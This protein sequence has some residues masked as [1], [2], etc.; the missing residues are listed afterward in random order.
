MQLIT[1]CAHV[2]HKEQAVTKHGVRE[3]VNLKVETRNFENWEFV[4]LK[5]MQLGRTGLWQKS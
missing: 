5:T 4:E 2:Q 3:L 1:E